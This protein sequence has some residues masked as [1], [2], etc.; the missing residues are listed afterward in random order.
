MTIPELLDRAVERHADKLWL[1]SEDERYTYGEAA[2]RIAAV[3]AALAADGIEHGDLRV[4]D[5]PERPG[6]P[7]HLAWRSCGSA[8]SSC[9]PTRAAAR[10]NSPASPGRR[11]PG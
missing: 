5:D 7:V 1:L 11:S 2:G 10:R 4:G 6:L 8:R 3:A 9:P